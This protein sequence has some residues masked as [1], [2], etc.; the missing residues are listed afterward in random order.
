MNS[1][2]L[3]A[4]ILITLLV[5]PAL[6]FLFLKT[7]GKNEFVLPYY[8]PELDVRGHTVVE[9]GD[10]LFHQIQNFELTNQK[11]SSLRLSDFDGD[12]KLVN[13]FFSRCGV[14]C[15]ILNSN[16][17]RVQETFKGDRSVQLLSISVDPE[18]DTAEVLGTYANE[19]GGA[20]LS[21]WHFLTGDKTYIYKMA[22]KDFKLPVSDASVY[23]DELLDVDEMFIHSEKVLLL[24]GDNFVRG[25]YDGTDLE[26]M[27]RIRLEV[28]VLKNIMKE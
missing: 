10:T 23:T 27:K 7:F 25:I 5:V 21:N 17:A 2:I 24:D 13:F 15:P 16:L 1:K 22:I 11:D 26:E 12:I 14:V 9:G 8:F 6:V 28:K 4:G 19:F 18:Y 3:K 20:S